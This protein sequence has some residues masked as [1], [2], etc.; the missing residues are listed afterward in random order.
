MEREAIAAL[1]AVLGPL[2]IV[3]VVIGAVAANRY[4]RDVR[5]T[6]DVDLLVADHGPGLAAF[7][8]ALRAAGWS[9]RRGTPDGAILRLR[10]RSLGVADIVLAETDYQ[11]EAIERARVEPG[12]GAANANVRV[13]RIEDVLIHKLIAGR[14]RDLADIEDILS[15][16]LPL[17]D[18]F[19]ERWAEYWDVLD[20]WRRLRS[21]PRP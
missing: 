12:G 21:A 10:H 1:A 3:W 19:V 18:G 20:L 8:S 5:L 16:G 17:D 14:P 11:R 6:G 15:G 9:T 2:G 13:L 4:R 7:E